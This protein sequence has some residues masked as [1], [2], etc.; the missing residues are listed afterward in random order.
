MGVVVGIIAGATALLGAYESGSAASNQIKAAENAQK[1]QDFQNALNLQRQNREITKKNAQ[2]W[3]M[4]KNIAEAANITRAEEEFWLRYNFNNE[5][6]TLG[7]NTKAANDSLLASFHGRGIGSNSQTA[8]QM[9]RMSFENAKQAMVDRRVQ[10]GTQ[11]LSAERKQDA[12]LARR[13]FGYQAQIPF[14]EG[15][16]N[17]PSAGAAMTSAMASGGIQ[18]ILGGITSGMAYNQ[19]NAQ[20]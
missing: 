10:H 12:A 16:T 5:S 8:K 7:R 15:M 19:A 17:S 14:M 11:M 3:Q 6:G 13:D 1:W 9:Q 4:N 18:A 20:A 2:K